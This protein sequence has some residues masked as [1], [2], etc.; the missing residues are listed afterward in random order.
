MV[1]LLLVMDL[2]I[3]CVM[4]IGMFRCPDTVIPLLWRHK[5]FMKLMS[6]IFMSLILLQ[7]FVRDLLDRTVRVLLL[8]LMRRDVTLIV[9]DLGCMRFISTA[10]IEE[11]TALVAMH[12]SLVDHLLRRS[13]LLRHNLSLSDSSSISYALDAMLSASPARAGVFPTYV[14]SRGVSL[15]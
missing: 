5:S 10:C 8:L 11:V 15:A 4:R 13:L 14:S 2:S 7:A 12:L 6:W 1:P 9:L 3:N